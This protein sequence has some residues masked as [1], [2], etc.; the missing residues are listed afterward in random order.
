LVLVTSV[1][2][3]GFVTLPNALLRAAP[4]AVAIIVAAYL[5]PPRLV[6]GIAAY[7]LALHVLAFLLE[8]P[9][10]LTPSSLSL[11]STAFFGFMAVALARKIRNEVVLRQSEAVQRARLEAVLRQA[12][13]G[14]IIATAPSGRILLANEQAERILGQSFPASASVLDYREY[15]GFHPNGRPYLLDEWPLVRS[16]RTGEVITGVEIEI[17]RPDGRRG[18]MRASAAPICDRQGH[19]VAVVA[20]LDDITERKRAEAERE[21]LATQLQL[22]LQSTDEGIFGVDTHDRCTFINRAGAEMLGF[23]PE[24][25]LGKVTHEVFHYK[26]P[27]GSPYPI[28]DCPLFRAVRTGRGMRVADEAFWRKD[29]TCFPVE[30]S[31][32]P[33]LEAGAVTGGM[34]S[35][36]D[37]T[38]RKQAEQLREEYVRLIS[39]DLRAPLTMI[40]GQA[41]WLRRLLDQQGQERESASAVAIVKNAKRMNAMI[42][43]MVDSARLEAGQLALRKEPTDLQQLVQDIRERLGTR[44]DRAR[45]SVEG[46]E[47]VPHVLA[48]RDQI[49][50]AVVNLLTNALKYSPPDSPVVIRLQPRD[51]EV[52]VS[53][54]D[55]G[56]GIPAEEIPQL[57]QRYYRASTGTK[58]EGLGLG[59]YITRL[60]VEAHGGRIGVE[61][62]VGKG[63]TFFFSLPVPQSG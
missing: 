57:F 50:R 29:G 28:E 14:I 53:V 13:S 63:S 51:G 11:V 49:E 26:H 39:H 2:V 16:I 56:V 48:D 61:S 7:A 36:L 58:A 42:Q 25:L 10:L 38:R 30:L 35:F 1:F 17:V 37:I 62:E 5:L 55:Q 24:E 60:V 12:P 19:L 6:L 44:E 3:L 15:Q 34:V 4:Y 8:E 43:E 20:V 54:I 40:M 33:V 22:L 27:D 47:Y 32:L 9:S 59:L 18:T 41:D 23:R 46:P 31:A 52:L 21:R 45:I